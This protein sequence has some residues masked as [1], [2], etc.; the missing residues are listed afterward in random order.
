MDTTRYTT[1]CGNVIADEVLEN[2]I[3]HGQYDVVVANIVADVIIG[4]KHELRSF[5]T[6]NGK[7]IAS[8][9]IG[10]RAEEVKG[11]LEEV[12]FEV[13][14]ITEKNDWVAILAHIK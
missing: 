12:G 7:L 1:Y 9:V 14:Q 8:G 10:D 11:H 13:D 5:L 3:G 6:E 2:K 4:M